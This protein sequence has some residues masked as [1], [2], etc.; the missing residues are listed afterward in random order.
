MQPGHFDGVNGITVSKHHWTTAQLEYMA[1]P[2][3]KRYP[4]IPDSEEAAAEIQLLDPQHS[5]LDIK[6]HLSVN[7]PK[8]VLSA[9]FSISLRLGNQSAPKPAPGGQEATQ[10]IHG[11]LEEPKSRRATNTNI[12]TIALGTTDR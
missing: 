8:S 5:C 1:K 4:F 12:G 6:Y 3:T 10:A 11:S 9:E 2:G 7:V